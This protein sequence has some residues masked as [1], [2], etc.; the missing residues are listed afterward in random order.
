[1]TEHIQVEIGKR[2]RKRREE[3]GLTQEA[4]ADLARTHRTYI[5][6]LER[7]EKRVSV[8]TLSRIAGALNTNL[9]R[10]LEGL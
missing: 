2:I 7:A 9:S 10:F 8:E 5:G 4:L 1:M 3:M 6:M